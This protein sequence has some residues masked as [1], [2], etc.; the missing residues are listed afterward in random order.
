MNDQ[1]IERLLKA[2]YSR[3]QSQAVL[4]ASENYASSDVLRAQ[5]SVLTNKYA[6]GYPGKRYYA[7]CRYVDEVEILAI[8]RLKE[9]YDAGY[10]NVQP[11]SGSDANMAVFHA[12]LKPG[13]VILGMALDAGGH[14]T[15]GH[16]AS[17]SGKLYQSYAYGLDEQGLVDYDSVVELAEKHKPK[18]IIAG[19]S[20]YSQVLDWAR[21]SEIA[22]SCGAYLLA[23]MAH[24]S[25][26]VASGH[27][28]SPLPYAD[29]VTSTTHKTLRGPRGGMILAR[30]ASEVTRK[31]DRSVFPGLQ[32]GPLM[33]VIAA[34]AVCFYEALQPEFKTYQQHV[35]L[36]A[37][38]MA[39][40]F[41]K[42]GLSVVSGSTECHIILLSLQGLDYNGHQAQ[43][44]LE[45]ADIIVNK[46]AIPNDPLP[47]QKTSGIRLGTSALTTMGMVENQA[48]QL[49]TWIVKLLSNQTDVQ[50][51]K[52]YVGALMKELKSLER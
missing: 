4:I 1:A 18:L 17:V 49:A 41:S 48:K 16:K 45:E 14:L 39:E 37:K 21:F 11:H 50:S 7:G 44:L 52:Q 46:N 29:L 25:G 32:G 20:A 43:T 8:Q 6:E 42:A 10:A 36:N 38:A 24:V 27:Y 28:P 26:L 12:L 47:P 33:H 51:V 5:G 3:Q 23:D 13:D 22:K 9:L 35:V 30:E 15:H 2:E 34:K 40:V 19:F 31:V